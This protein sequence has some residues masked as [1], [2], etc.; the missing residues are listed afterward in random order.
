MNKINSLINILGIDREKLPDLVPPGTMLGDLT[1]KAAEELGLPREVKTAV[2]GQDLQCCLLGS[3]MVEDYQAHCY[4]G[5]GSWVQCLM[6]EKRNDVFKAMASLPA[7]IPGRYQCINA[8]EIAGG[9]LTH[10]IRNV[11][12]CFNCEPGDP[13]MDEEYKIFNDVASRVPPGANGVIYT[14]WLVGEMSPVDD[15]YIRGGLHNL[16][17]HNTI[18]DITRGVYE[19]VAFNTRWLSEAT[20]GFVKRRF[21][22]I[23]MVG[24]GAESDLWCQIFADVMNKPIKQM[25]EPIQ[26]NI[27]G[28]AFIALAAL[29][30]ISWSDISNLVN[31]RQVF[32]P[33]RR[34][35]KLYDDLYG[36]FQ[37]IYKKNKGI[38]KRLNSL[39]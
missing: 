18:N 37:E 32:H 36:V 35:R 20:E 9:C 31:C 11:V 19:G 28:A 38:Y 22:D 13:D 10:L 23:A 30:E 24:G 14:P 1:V 5:T 8:Q 29:G 21:P 12:R 7:A 39:G 15:H 27:R 33:E 4:I 2:G 6:P 34:N 17:M 3:G 16:S 26:A 25:E